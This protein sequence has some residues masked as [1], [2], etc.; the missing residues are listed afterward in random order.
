M[1]I[2]LYCIQYSSAGVGGSGGSGGG[3]AESRN[4]MSSLE[5]PRTLRVRLDAPAINLTDYHFIK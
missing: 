1:D 4:E 3:S 2:V 5:L